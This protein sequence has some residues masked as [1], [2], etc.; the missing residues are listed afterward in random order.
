[1]K[2]FLSIVL[3]MLMLLSVI[4]AAPISTGA[5]QVTLADTGVT[6]TGGEVLY[7]VPNSNWNEASA[8][9]AIYL[10]GTGDA[11]ASMTKVDGEDNLY[12]VTV[13]DGNWT[14]VIF[15]RMNPGATANNW[16]N[17]WNQTNDLAYD[18]T[19]NCYTI[20]AGAWDKG[21]GTWSVYTPSTSGGEPGEP[22]PEPTPDPEP[23]PE[24]EYMTIY[25]EN[26]W[27][28]TDST[29]YYWGSAGTNPEWPGLE[30]TYVD[31]T[32][33]GADRYTIEVPTDIAGMTFV[34]TGGYGEEQCAD[35]TE[36]W[37]D[38]ICYYM[39]YDSE[40][41]TKPAGSYEYAP[42]PVPENFTV[43]FVD[44]VDNFSTVY[45]YAYTGDDT[46][47]EEPGFE[48]TRTEY[49]T[50][51]GGYVYSY[52]FDKEY[53]NII[54][55][56]INV[57]NELQ[58][59]AELEFTANKYCY[60]M[61]EVW[62]DNL[63]AVEAAI[64]GVNAEYITVY[65]QN[66]W[67]WNDVKVYYWGSEY[68]E[69]AAHPGET[70]HFF[71][72]DGT[73]DVYYYQIPADADGFL[74]NGVKDDGSGERDTT[75]DITENFYDGA[76][77]SMMW[78][79]GND[80]YCQDISVLFPEEPE[81]PEVPEEETK[82]DLKGYKITLGGTIG[83]NFYY[84]LSDDVLNDADA[85]V[86]F[87]VPDTGSTY[88]VEIPVS[89][90]SW[91]EATGFYYATCNVAAKE[92]TST[93]TAQLV[94]SLLETEAMEYSVQAYAVYILENPDK[95]AAELDLVKALLNYGAASQVYFNYNIDNLANDISLELMSEEDKTITQANIDSFA[96]VIEGEGDI[97]K[98]VGATLTLKSETSLNFYFTL[99]DETI[100]NPG[101]NVNGLPGAPLEKNGDLYVF[102]VEDIF[103][104]DLGTAYTLKIGNGCTITYSAL[105]YAYLAQQSSKQSLV[106][107]ANAL[108]AY[109]VAVGL[110]WSE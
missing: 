66:N 87:T 78:N 106:D 15:C 35:I 55:S 83:V 103:A 18:G 24:I 94:T 31:T 12:E 61:T 84:D 54:F 65:F 42:I 98:F 30:M 90:L 2:K 105:S 69:C 20:T 89:M 104:H 25:F 33:N 13:P 9:F 92:M 81:E 82:A 53:E 75:P 45:A 101:I 43:Y 51:E 102:T 85:K 93:I 72:N 95:Y 4:C 50:S 107:V 68:V 36:G 38:G 1:M 79:D 11:W 70:M 5:A 39:T 48:M 71:D 110:Y 21:A 16:N 97:V 80:V 58:Q 88:T 109:Y 49:V 10:Y 60:W 37:Y 29:I 62:Y 56:G 76:C 17:K 46:A 99:S 7:L 91:D 27:S 32:E 22:E 3:T 14:N 64:K 26:N 77:Y 19:K 34:G 23:D 86:V 40:T 57:V 8:R 52:T 100:E 73:Y 44:S 108:S 28:W 74:F 47:A 41:N 59:T 63:E 67:M 96:P 6:M